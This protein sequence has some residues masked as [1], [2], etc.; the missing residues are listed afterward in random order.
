LHHKVLWKIG[1]IME[2]ESLE[3]E[4]MQKKEALAHLSAIRNHLVDKQIFFP[5]NYNAVYIWSVIAIILTF[6][7]V[8]MYEKGIAVGTG[9]VFVLVTI[10]FISEGVM[11]KKVNKSY[12]IEDCTIRQQFI[13]KNFMM[14]SL[15]LIIMSAALA[16]YELYIP[17]YLMWL[18]LI[19]LGYHAVG[20][21]LNIRLFSKMAFFNIIMSFILLSMSAYNGHLVGTASDCF[22]LVQGAIVLGLAVLPAMVA[23]HQKKGL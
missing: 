6:I 12:D 22:H 4:T 7:M 2:N 1:K 8:P 17:I 21:V 23:W 20:Y 11:T 18:F 15:Y 10:G 3:Q 5:Y 14:I 13:M 9:I 16:M 19:S